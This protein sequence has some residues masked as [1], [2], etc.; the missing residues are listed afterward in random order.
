METGKIKMTFRE[1]DNEAFVD[2]ICGKYNC[3]L[4]SGR[5]YLIIVSQSDAKNKTRKNHEDD[6]EEDFED[7]DDLD[8]EIQDAY[9]GGFDDGYDA[10]Y[11]DGYLKAKK[12]ARRNG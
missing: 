10:G 1:L 2:L 12:E 5:L 11:A 9:D 8:D 3:E 7:V 4:D 6:L